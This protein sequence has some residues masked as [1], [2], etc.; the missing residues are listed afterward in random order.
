MKKVLLVTTVSG[1]VPQFEMNNVK[2][3]QSLGAEVHYAANYNTPSY[4][5]DN[6]RLDGTEIIRHQIDFVRSPF[7]AA[8]FTAYAQLKELMEKEKFDMVHCHTPMGAVMARLAAHATGTQPVI[9]T[10]HGFH[11]FKGAPLR[12]WLFYY[13]V[14]KILSKYTQDQ[15]CI[16]QEDYN[17]AKKKFYADY[18]DYIPGVGIDLT[19]VNLFVEQRE[20]Y[21]NEKRAEL[22][23]TKN[24]I[25]ILSVGE[26]IKRKNH[27]TIIRMIAERKDKRLLYVIAGHGELERELKNLAKEL[28]IEEQILFLGYCKDIYRVYLMADLFIFPSYQE[29][30][31]RALLE[32]MAC[33]LP[34][35]CSDIRGSRDLL[36]TGDTIF[37]KNMIIC[38]GG[39]LVNRPDDW[40]L[41]NNALDYMLERHV[42]WE[43][44]G[45]ENKDRT[46]EFEISQVGEIMESIYKRWI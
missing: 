44:M 43:N 39:I 16:N 25:V 1:F 29:G 41:Y 20:K 24:C 9:Y 28:H 35:I 40:Q 42:E 10:A 13:P 21:R 4:G 45:R 38:P 33:A 32:A 6:S 15:I 18:V 2:I 11:F 46:K 19:N 23:I 30:L 3:L 31:P 22:S 37:E 36:K 14:E 17:L 5:D 27:S 12:N 26:L 7:K 8:N 34:V